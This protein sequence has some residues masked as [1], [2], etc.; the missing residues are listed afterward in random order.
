MKK[1]I[2]LSIL[3]F[4]VAYAGFG[5]N[6]LLTIN[7]SNNI[8]LPG[9]NYI[10]KDPFYDE[11]ALT[12]IGIVSL[13]DG[14]TNASISTLKGANSGD[15]IGED[16]IAILSN[17]NFI[18]LSR[19]IRVNGAKILALTFMKNN[20][21]QDLT[22]NSANSIF[23]NYSVNFLCDLYSLPNGNFLIDYKPLD[24]YLHGYGYENYF[25]LVKLNELSVFANES[26]LNTL[27]YVGTYGTEFFGGTSEDGVQGVIIFSDSK[28]VVRVNSINGT[29]ALCFDGNST[30][31]TFHEIYMGQAY[32]FG[33]YAISGS[34][35]FP[36][37]YILQPRKIKEISKIDEN[38]YKVSFVKTS[39]T[40]IPIRLNA[41]NFESPQINVIANKNIKQSETEPFLLVIPF[42]TNPIEENQFTAKVWLN[43]PNA[44]VNGGKTYLSRHFEITPIDNT[45]I[46]TGFVKLYFTQAEFDS[47][48]S[49]S[50]NQLKLP[51]GPNDTAGKHNLQI[52]KYAGTSSNNY[53]L[54]DSYTVSQTIINPKDTDITWNGTMWEVGFEVTGFSGFFVSTEF[55][56]PLPLILKNFTAKNYNGQIKL[57]WETINEVNVRYFEIQR[58]EDSKKFEEIGTVNPNNNSEKSNYDF[59]DSKAANTQI[60]YYRL[61]MVDFDGKI[62]FSKV[63]AIKI[64]KNNTITISPNPVNNI[65]SINL[66]QNLDLLYTNGQ[67]VNIKGQKIK[68]IKFDKIINEFFLDNIT[69]GIYFIIMTDGTK[70]KFIKK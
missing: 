34:N 42:G 60:I 62:N 66:N 9:G 12:D 10:V 6:G 31:N 13:Y 8:T 50:S 70:I 7:T 45:T 5:Q 30:D 39:Q 57:N 24:A 65:M 40:Y 15:K 58:S 64:N 18:V 3:I 43:E 63:E 38:T 25:D 26:L 1:V 61:K 21:V 17:G 2:T 19:I 14:A 35:V 22:L 48:N 23:K 36:W 67:I 11:G 16:G 69:P 53:G 47:Y 29:N 20:I 41:L 68:E 32:S 44:F 27:I 55:E 49:L 54:P 51:T 33:F 56:M 52:V 59:L 46:K 4:L 28:F 37:P